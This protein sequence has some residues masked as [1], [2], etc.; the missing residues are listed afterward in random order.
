MDRHLQLQ[1]CRHC[2]NRKTDYRQGMLCGLTGEKA[3]FEDNCPDFVKDE[4]IIERQPP[5]YTGEQE[6]VSVHEIRHNL[7]HEVIENYRIQQNMYAGSLAATIA[8]LA[9][10]TIWALITI[11]T[12][13]QVGYMAFAVGG[14]VGLG[15]RYFGKGV[16]QI[17]GITAAGI[18]LLSCVLG[19]FLSIYFWAADFMNVGYQ[20]V[21]NILGYNHGLKYM[22]E[23]FHF[24]DVIFYGLAVYTGYR[25]SFRNISKKDLRPN[26]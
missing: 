5:P 7:P 26:S 25:L 19:N 20:S 22:A 13:Y 3:E 1:Q 16:D 10:A 23:N 12:G 24:M 14:M 21:F 17:Y 4:T 2:K 6:S 8:G 15:M 11:T 18:A 9:G